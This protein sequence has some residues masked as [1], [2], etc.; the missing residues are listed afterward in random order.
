MASY[1]C[2]VGDA[3]FLR[4]EYSSPNM[5]D[6]LGDCLKEALE[7]VNDLISDPHKNAED[8]ESR[9]LWVMMQLPKY[10]SKRLS[11]LPILSYSGKKVCLPPPEVL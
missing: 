10:N 6:I 11:E 7:I 1:N 9:A 8:I 4:G 5:R 2:Y 3:A